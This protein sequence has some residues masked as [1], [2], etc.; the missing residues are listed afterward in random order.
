MK[1]I[2]L[3]LALAFS[4]SNFNAQAQSKNEVKVDIDL[5]IVKED[6]VMVTVTP[7][8][9]N[10]D[11][12]AYHIPKIVPGTYS[13]DDYGKYVDNLKAYDAKGNAL[14]V[15]KM[16]DNSWTIRDAKKLVKITYW[17]NDTY[18]I[19]DSHDIFSPAGTNI[20]E[21][22]NFMLNMHGF[23][24]YFDNQLTVPYQLNMAHPSTLWGATSMTDTDAS[25]S[26]DSF[27]VSRYAEL[28]ENPIMYAKPD[29]TT[30]N[31]NG[32]DILIA[33]YSPTGLV[34]A[35]NITPGMKKMVTAQKNFLGKFN[36]TKKYTVLLYL[37]DVNGKDAQ[38]FGALEHPTATTVVMPEAMPLEQLSEQMKDVVSHEFF[39]IVTPLSIHSK[40]IHFFDYNH[41][42]M[43]QHLWMYEGVT[44]YFANLF[45]VNQG[46]IT[47][48]EFYTRMAGKIANASNMNDTMPFTQM[49]ANVLTKPYKDQYL[50]VYE[51][52]AL[53]GMCI[54]IIIR[55]KS[56]GE[57]G[58]LD[59]MQKLATAYGQNNPFDDA[60]LFAK[61]TQLTY[62]EVGDFLKTYVSGETPIP[63]DQFFARMG[64]TKKAT[65]V[66]GNVFLKGQM[67][68]I[69]V[70]PQTKE[71]VV[72]PQIALPDFYSTLG[73][74][75]GDT[76]T[77]INGT[78][79]NLDNIYD[80]I[81][82]SA[83]WKESDPITVKIKREGKE[84]TLTGKVKL[85]YEDA[86]TW[87]ATD[88]SKEKLKQAW[89]KG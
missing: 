5:N 62:P 18:D 21:G 81:M 34:T 28:V 44:E 47:E 20:L 30:F 87:E 45:Q 85:P 19:E 75:G 43:S 51:K 4:A 36:S 60:D 26:K 86:S 38:G 80:M 48:D 73:L 22:K 41:P 32:M 66:P 1:K 24:G 59:L 46:L 11:E 79:Y 31:V 76:I 2:I 27:T 49:S 55:E 37:T 54:D 13:E 64:V 61:I 69:T 74:K 33:V 70:N 8:K 72:L 12:V 77:E 56:N 16:D 68:Y 23:V 53:I 10:A 82:G 42:K 63:Y 7:P 50:N 84:M 89:L 78:A 9:I 52:G 88:K 35:E 29:Y 71:I 3:T 57:R 14:V 39:H 58:I 40:E 65:K 6:K 25:G 17:V 15:A 67:P 83:N